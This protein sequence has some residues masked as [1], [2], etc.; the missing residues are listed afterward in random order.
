[1]ADYKKPTIDSNY[2]D[3]VDELHQAI[4]ATATWNDGNNQNIP[5]G[6]K[7]WNDTSKIFEKYTGTQWI[8]LSSRYN[9]PVYWGSIINKPVFD[10]SVTSTSTTTF[11]TPKAVNTAFN[12]AAEGVTKAN[13][14]KTTADSARSIAD[15]AKTTADSARSIANTAKTTA[16]S[17]RSIADTAKTA[18]NKTL[19]KRILFSGAKSNPSKS[20]ITFNLNYDL[21]D[22]I[23][24][25]VYRFVSGDISQ[26]Y[27]EAFIATQ[28][29]VNLNNSSYLGSGFKIRPD[30]R[31]ID[32]TAPGVMYE[33]SVIEL[34]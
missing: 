19:R 14:A 2:I 29:L 26:L 7:R 6:A 1:M 20:T 33:I 30:K 5:V 15:T 23:V 13:E 17:A 25:V 3:F 8:A 18:S 24:N 28:Y 16:D 34:G 10:S 31:S 27:S 32:F 9:L 4:N 22:R 11:A 21:T 12:K